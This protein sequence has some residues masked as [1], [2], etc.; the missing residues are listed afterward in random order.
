M[1]RIT[2]ICSGDP[3]PT[4]WKRLGEWLRGQSVSAGHGLRISRNPVTGTTIS[5]ITDPSYPSGSYVHPF[6]VSVR[7][8][9]GDPTLF[10][11]YGA[12]SFLMLSDDT[13]PPYNLEIQTAW[14]SAADPIEFLQGDPMNAGG[15]V[16][17]A[18][19]TP[20]TTYGVW[21]VLTA[22]PDT[23]ANPFTTSGEYTNLVVWHYS[24]SDCKVVV[25]S[26]AT[27]HLAA[28][29]GSAGEVGY[30]L[31]QVDVD[32]NGGATIKQHRKSDL[33]LPLVALPQDIQFPT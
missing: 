9:E 25:S 12:A 7:S 32:A 4:K 29:S 28:Y 23:I 22:S 5:A 8:I 19:L 31:A 30:F 6:K 27:S 3:T 13:N 21:L 20:S 24:P 26:T 1:D 15:A 14:D 18:V 33:C 2:D 17:F 16:G 11:A 10:V